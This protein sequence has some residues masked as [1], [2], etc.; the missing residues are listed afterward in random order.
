MMNEQL[1]N[2]DSISDET[3]ARATLTY[4]LDSADAL[5]YAAI[6]G[7]HNASR[8][9]QLLV[10]LLP[11]SSVSVRKE[12]TKAIE[13][14]F[15]E[16]AAQWGRKVNAR[17][18]DTFHRC[19]HRWVTRLGQLPTLD[20]EALRDWFSVGGT[21]WIIDP[22]SMY[23]PEQLQD[24]SIRKDW[25]APLCLWGKGEPGSLT[26]CSQPVAI[27]GSRGATDYGISVTR[28]VARSLAQHGHTIISGGAMGIDAAAHRGALSTI[29]SDA[30]NTAEPLYSG[31]TIAVFAGGLNHI[32]P[33]C[34]SELF[35]DIMAN[36]GALISELCPG[37]IP[38][39]R[40][41][42]LRNR[43]IAALAST[44]VVAQ[45]RPRSG[46]LN[47][48]NWAVELGRN[49]YAV[50]GDITSP[51]H[52]GC[53]A[54]IRDNKAMIICSADA[55]NELTHEPHHITF[56]PPE[57]SAAQHDGHARK[58]PSSDDGAKQHSFHD[59]GHE[60]LD[61]TNT[62]VNDEHLIM[63]VNPA[64]KNTTG[65]ITMDD[66]T[67][68]D[69]VST[70]ETTASDPRHRDMLHTIRRCSK[71]NSKPSIDMVIEQCRMDSAAYT[72][73]TTTEPGKTAMRADSTMPQPAQES[74]NAMATSQPTPPDDNSLQSSVD[75][76][77]NTPP[78]SMESSSDTD[79]I[80]TGIPE[81]YGHMRS[82][83]MPYW[84]ALLGEMEL[85]GIISI[86][87]GR[88]NIHH[89]RRAS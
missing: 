31:V 33:Q 86:D 69:A 67:R 32:G 18:M 27:V 45:A 39:A 56:E 52:A 30:G 72:S 59:N 2:A 46:A 36:H 82:E 78:R 34:N 75:T 11:S 64:G 26:C 65:G 58:Q 28:H 16:G 10:S 61:N 62:P 38:E 19:L 48:A 63:T 68:T 21:Q 42:L 88:I 53:N 37:T 4:C 84:L 22:D 70:N 76:Q 89:P 12:A 1:P 44:V 23:W 29:V 3:L 9:L 85:L 15:I 47:T 5:M 25:A 54:L 24:L 74:T 13:R 81:P 43:I 17:G 83:S 40:R 49:V 51:H 41:F 50:P 55:T 14:A 57:S 79:I 35:S 60:T 77:P 66:S 8:V 87:N 73:Q 71:H 80:S 7:T 20:P 6:K